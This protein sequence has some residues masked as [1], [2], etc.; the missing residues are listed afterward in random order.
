MQNKPNFKIGK[1]NLNLYSTRAYKNE[2]A[3]RVRKNKPK[4]SQFQNRQNEPKLC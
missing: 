2:T 3:F 4:Q 1:M